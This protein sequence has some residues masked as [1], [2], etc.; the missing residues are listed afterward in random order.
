MQKLMNI[1]GTD[2][3]SV[4]LALPADFSL[5]HTRRDLIAK[6]NAT[7]D[8]VKREQINVLIGMIEAFDKASDE[9]YGLA[10]AIERQVK[11]VAG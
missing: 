2:G 8:P 10:K 7:S 3:G 4:T 6:R 9:R 1:H 11:I 5:Y